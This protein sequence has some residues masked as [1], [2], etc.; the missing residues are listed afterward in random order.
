MTTRAH[1]FA[2]ATAAVVSLM[3]APHATGTAQQASKAG[4]HSS[5]IGQ[6]FGSD[7]QL[8]LT[9]DTLQS[10]WGSDETS[11]PLAVNRERRR[12]G[13]EIYAKVAPAVVVVRTSHGHGTGFFIQSDGTFITNNHV[14]DAGLRHDPQRNASYAMAYVGQLAGDGMMQ[15]RD[16]PIRAHVLKVDLQ[17]DLA[18]LKLDAPSATTYP[19][20]PLATTAPK[21]GVDCE[22][23]GHP[24]SGLLWTYRVGQVSGIGQAPRDL[25]WDLMER[26]AVSGPRRAALEQRLS[27]EPSFR[28]LLTSTGAGPG[29]SGGPLLDATG[30]VIGVTH[31][32]TAEPRQAR[33]T[34]HIHLDEV[35]QFL[36]SVPKTPV[37]LAPDPWRFGPRAVLR[38]I[39]GGGPPDVLVAGDEGP[40]V[41]LFDLDNDTPAQLLAGNDALERLVLQRKWD[42]ELAIDVRGAGYDVF[43]DTDNDGAVDLILTTDEAQPTSK[44]RLVRSAGG[45]WRAD[46]AAPGERLLSSQYF[47]VPGLAR[48]MAAMQN[49]LDALVR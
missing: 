39:D 31:A 43:Y 44:D 36:A 13:A 29:D 23:V 25:V 49:A 1:R 38:D 30:A 10:M 24:G 45:Q 8:V 47:K 3:I 37:I 17:R 15:L 11:A 7:V 40:E 34:H 5:P 4:F 9:P 35:R 46:R 6:R 48:R 14:V 26:L 32:V 2:A 27:Q 20:L 28:L 16:Q 33:F 21:P 41:M 42:F 22:I 18:L 19:A 12:G